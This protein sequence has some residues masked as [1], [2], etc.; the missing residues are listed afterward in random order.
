MRAMDWNNL[1]TALS[2]RYIPLM[3]WQ[4]GTTCKIPKKSL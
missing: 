4:E 3:D 1:I 2:F